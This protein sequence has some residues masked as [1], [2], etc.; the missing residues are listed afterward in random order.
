MWRG[1]YKG[2]GGSYSWGVRRGEEG[3]KVRA[4]GLCHSKVKCR[5]FAGGPVA[6]MLHFLCRVPGLD[7]WSGT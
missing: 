1:Q 7:P 2:G 5:D 6:K 3:V 4:W